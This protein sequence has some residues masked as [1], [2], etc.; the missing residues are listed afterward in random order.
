MHEVN[1]S[2]I[3]VKPQQPFVDWLLHCPDPPDISSVKQQVE[4]DTNV[5]LLPEYH[6]DKESKDEFLADI[7]PTIA[8]AEFRAWYTDEDL[9]GDIPNYSTFKNWFHVEISSMVLD[10]TQGPLA[11]IR[12]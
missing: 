8:A 3:L 2:A 9:W 11:R 6:P 5:Y 7:Y 4:N 12:Y 10:I 1:R